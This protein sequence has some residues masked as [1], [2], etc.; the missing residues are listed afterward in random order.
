MVV[1][2]H[3]YEMVS[4]D[5]RRAAE[6]CPFCFHILPEPVATPIPEPEPEALEYAYPGDP[7]IQAMGYAA[8][9]PPPPKSKV[10]VIVGG[11]LLV[12]ALGVGGFF[13]FGKKDA[14]QS[15]GGKGPAAKG[16]DPRMAP[17][18]K[19]LNE[20]VTAATEDFF[21]KTC[22][23][24]QEVDYS[25]VTQL[26]M[27][28][29]EWRSLIEPGSGSAGGKEDWYMC[30]MRILEI[31]SRADMTLELETRFVSGGLFGSSR[32]FGKVNLKGVSVKSIPDFPLPSQEYGIESWGEAKDTFHIRMGFLSRGPSALSRLNGSYR[33]YKLGSDMHIRMHGTR[34]VQTKSQSANRQYGTFEAKVPAWF[35][36][37]Y[38]KELRDWGTGCNNDVSERFRRLSNDLIEKHDD[39]E[40]FKDSPQLKNYLDKAEKAGRALC[41]AMPNVMKI[42]ELHDQEKIGE[43]EQLKET[44]KAALETAR[45]VFTDD[46]AKFIDEMATNQ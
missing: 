29:D 21:K 5:A 45:K 10:P 39:L 27:H 23:R 25:F 35:G 36:E 28:S 4:K 22:L 3:C 12:A 37:S 1:C 16:P 15:G 31:R 41:D 14:E 13:I 17:A 33:D 6:N 44:L 7:S 19:G 8:A 32:S 43:A 20:K 46:L 24:F 30:P 40:L 11:L 42:I 38:S 2:S 9:A 18:F 26:T 34:L